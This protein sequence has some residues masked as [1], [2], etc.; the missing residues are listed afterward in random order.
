MIKAVYVHGGYKGC[1]RHKPISLMKACIVLM[2]FL[3]PKD[4]R[5]SSKKETLSKY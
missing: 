5:K 3:V 1:A 4:E 2:F